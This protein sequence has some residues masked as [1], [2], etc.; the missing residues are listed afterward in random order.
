MGGI[1]RKTPTG[2]AVGRN[3]VWHNILCCSKICYA[4]GQYYRDCHV[5]EKSRM[6]HGVCRQQ[7]IPD[8]VF[9]QVLRELFI[10]LVLYPLVSAIVTWM[11]CVRQGKYYKIVT[12]QFVSFSNFCFTYLGQSICFQFYFDQIIQFIISSTLI[13]RIKTHLF[14]NKNLF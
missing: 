2:R 7:I 1:S 14:R 4:L 8:C 12:F 13:L 11:L 6:F 3:V 10:P 5:T 9:V